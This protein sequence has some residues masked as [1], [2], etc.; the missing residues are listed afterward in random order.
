[1]RNFFRR[2]VHI[3]VSLLSY[4]RVNLFSSVKT[5]SIFLP[6]SKI[7]PI[8]FHSDPKSTGKMSNKLQNCKTTHVKI[9]L[10]KDD[11]TV[12]RHII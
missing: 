5:G 3:A 4:L 7:C 9:I 10:F 2:F 8:L 12:I 6:F 1:M 11:L